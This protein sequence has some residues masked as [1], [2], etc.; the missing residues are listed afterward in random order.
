MIDTPCV[1]GRDTASGAPWIIIIGVG[2]DAR[3]TEANHD[4]P[5][6]RL[7]GDQDKRITR[8]FDVCAENLPRVSGGGPGCNSGSPAIMIERRQN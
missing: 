8:E 2:D 6:R 3:V 7:R 5:R 4:S 1:K